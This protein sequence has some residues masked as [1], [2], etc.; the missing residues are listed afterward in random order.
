MIWE[1]ILGGNTRVTFSTE[2]YG[3]G[4]PYD[5]SYERSV[6]ENLVAH[7]Y[8]RPSF[9]GTTI[10]GQVGT[11]ITLTDTNN[12]LNNYDVYASNGAEVR[13]DGN[14]ITITPIISLLYSNFSFSFFCFFL[15]IYILPLQ[16]KL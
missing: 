6:I 12:V 4:T 16:L 13:I 7:H 14:N 2:R 15:A 11:P 3:K 1:T 9:N 10:T 8:D 5:V